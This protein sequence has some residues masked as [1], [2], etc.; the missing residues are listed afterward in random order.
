MQ[1]MHKGPRDL[2]SSF[3]VMH[4]QPQRTFRF[5]QLG[6][7]QGCFLTSLRKGRTSLGEGPKT[8][9]VLEGFYEKYE[10]VLGADIAPIFGCALESHQDSTS[11]KPLPQSGST[12]LELVKLRPQDPLAL[13]EQSLRLKD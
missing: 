7:L 4:K 5:A 10:D 12:F 1:P 8:W 2:R 9:V 6:Y 3:E 11:S 13:Q